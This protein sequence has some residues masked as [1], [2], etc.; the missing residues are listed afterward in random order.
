MSIEKYLYILFDMSV[1]IFIDDTMK[2]EKYDQYTRD[3]IR[4]EKMRWREMM[5]HS[6]F[7][8]VRR[9][10]GSLKF[11][12]LIMLQEQPMHGY[13]LMK[14]IEEKYEHPI[15]QGIIYPTL[16]MLEDQGY[17]QVIEQNSKKIYNLT[18]EGK[19]YLDENNKIIELIKA[20]Q[21]EPQ[22]RSMP[23][24]K[25]QFHELASLIFS[26]Y[27]DLD[28]DKL[29]QIETLLDDARKRIGKVIFEG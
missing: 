8:P 27:R 23:L 11:I 20:R 25:K 24:I 29:K 18:A 3:Q 16:Q 1:D 5:V 14:Q 9:E 15:S 10:R 7:G 19:K 22:W 26:N 4:M 28:D 6:M 12:I 17:V 13:A 21:E 2:N